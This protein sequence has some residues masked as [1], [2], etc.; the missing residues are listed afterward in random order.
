MMHSRGFSD[1]KIKV[2]V[3]S[4]ISKEHQKKLLEEYIMRRYRDGHRRRNIRPPAT[5]VQ[6]LRAAQPK[7]RPR[8]WL[9]PEYHQKCPYGS[10]FREIYHFK[11]PG[12]RLL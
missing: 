6:A 4:G 8:A 12:G 3:H 1:P 10:F 2:R 7:D 9:L 5:T 11:C